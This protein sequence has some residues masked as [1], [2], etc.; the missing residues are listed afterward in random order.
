M[1]SGV[2][3]NGLGSGID[4]GLITDSIVAQRSRP[5]QQLQGKQIELRTRSESLKQLNAKLINLTEAGRALTD[6]AL[7]SGRTAG[8]SDANIVSASSTDAATPAVVDLV[9]TRLATSFSQAS[10]T[11]TATETVL[12][13]GATTATFTLRKGGDA[14]GDKTITID[15][16]NN[17]ITGL[18]DAINAAGADVTA[19]VVDTSGTGAFKLVLTSKGTGEAGR[20]EVLD[21]SA[22]FN[23]VSLAALNPPG[24]TT[25]FS[26]LNASLTLNGLAI[27]RQTN[28][29]TD[30]TPGVT[31]N[32]KKTGAANITV[33]AATSA[34]AD[35]LKNFVDAYNAVQDFV[36]GQYIADGRGRPSGVL[37]GDPTLRE[38]QRQLRDTIGGDSIANGGVFKNLAEI[39]VGRDASGKMTLDRTVLDD[40]LKTSFG[41]VRA[42][43]SGKTATDKGLAHSIVASYESLSNAD[44]GIVQNAIGGFTASIKN[45]DDNIAA[46]QAR[47]EAL[48]VSL[49]RQFAA[50][51]AAIGQLNGQNTAL[52][53]IIKSLEPRSN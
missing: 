36:A 44:T 41:D 11:F 25:D 31:Y 39:G 9:V 51:D 2:N 19:S 10:R 16:T 40:K 20:V 14:G 47:V 42:L 24:A 17:T 32:L 43:L 21:P 45:M 34:V 33:T 28:T 48:R 5:I 7:G 35:K 15:S 50:A 29:I 26:A 30:A 27:T 38:V 8:S 53:N 13:G 6:R 12:A 1:A 23:N 4:F 3:F 18:R 52:G 46:Q 22:S 49:T 37:A